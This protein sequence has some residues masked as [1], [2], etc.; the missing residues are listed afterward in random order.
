MSDVEEE[1]EVGMYS[2]L[3]YNVYCAFIDITGLSEKIVQARVVKKGG[4]KAWVRFCE[5]YYRVHMLTDGIQQYRVKVSFHY[6]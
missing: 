5:H 2:K 3:T 6:F 4:K 1:Y